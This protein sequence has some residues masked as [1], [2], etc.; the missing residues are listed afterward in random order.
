MKRL[1]LESW[2]SKVNAGKKEKLTMN[3]DK[4]ADTIGFLMRLANYI[5]KKGGKEGGNV[6]FSCL[7]FGYGYRA[8]TRYLREGI[9]TLADLQDDNYRLKNAFQ[10]TK[11]ELESRPDLDRLTDEG[12]KKVEDFYSK[13]L[14]KENKAFDKE[15]KAKSDSHH[16]YIVLEMDTKVDDRNPKAVW[17]YY[18]EENAREVAQRLIKRAFEIRKVGMDSDDVPF[19]TCLEK[20]RTYFYNYDKKGTASEYYVTIKKVEE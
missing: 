13:I 5:D 11:T 9:K 2:R 4:V 1:K 18:D 15:M 10:F 6:V 16:M 20:C 19:T 7:D 14:D 8:F 17:V 12:A 3:T